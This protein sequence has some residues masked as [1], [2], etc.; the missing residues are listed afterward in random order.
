[1]RRRAARRR[2]F[3]LV[4]LM[5]SLVLFSV[6][7]AGVLSVA[8]TIAQGFREQ[9]AAVATE[10]QV[11]APMDFL[12]DAI[13]QTGPAVQTAARACAPGPCVVAD[14]GTNAFI[15]D[16]NNAACDIGTIVVTNS[17]TAADTL[18]VLYASGAAVT[19][20]RAAFGPGT[21]ALDITDAS[22]LS[23]GDTILITDLTQGSTVTI[24]SIA[25][26]TLTLNA[27]GCGAIKWPA[28]GQYNAG[29]TIVRVLRA[30]FTVVPNTP[31]V[32][33]ADG[34]PVL[35]FDP[36]GP[37]G[38]A[39]AEPLAEGVEDMQV[40]LGVDVNG[41]GVIDPLTEWAF[42]K[43]GHGALAGPILAVKIVLVGRAITTASGTLGAFTRPAAFDHPAGAAQDT[44]RRR[45]LESTIEL[46]N[47][48]GSP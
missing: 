22:Q 35:M 5:V 17:T 24:A 30:R 42:D 29:A 11:R 33:P 28:G 41:V 9:R 26:N 14:Y 46:R 15:Q 16:V 6:A 47:M 3:T 1:V 7:I 38:P 23:A 36:D 48:G 31:G 21:T 18:D 12:G 40:A 4:E 8:V 43:T 37:N 2:G 44:F 25:G 10:G 34:V 13:R 39:Q 32:T 45:V 27:Q 19:S 20:T